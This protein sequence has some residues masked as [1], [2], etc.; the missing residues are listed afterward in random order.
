MLCREQTLFVSVKG[1]EA[2]VVSHLLSLRHKI[3]GAVVPL[4]NNI[5]KLFSSTLLDVCLLQQSFAVNKSLS[6]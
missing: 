4:S 3:E 5:V 2:L 6:W 1:A